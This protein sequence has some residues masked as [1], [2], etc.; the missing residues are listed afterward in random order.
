MDTEAPRKISMR[1]LVEAIVDDYQDLDKP[2]TLEAPDKINL[3]RLGNVFSQTSENTQVLIRDHQR[4]LCK[5]R[6]NA[7]R[8]ALTNLIENA[9]KYGEQARV[10]LHATS[11]QFTIVVT[12]RGS[13]TSFEQPEKLLE[14]FVRGENAKLLKGAGLGLTITNSVVKSHG[15]KLTFVQGA[16]GLEVTMELPRW[17]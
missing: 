3:D 14:P 17:I 5:C 15:G 16:E 9:L 7:I 2:V 12:D 13:H 4:V 10:A 1:S 6:P 11:D 8:R